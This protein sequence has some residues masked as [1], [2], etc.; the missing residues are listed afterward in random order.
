MRKIWRHSFGIQNIV[1]GWPESGGFFKECRKFEL[2]EPAQFLGPFLPCGLWPNQTE[3]QDC[4]VS[5]R[6]AQHV[7]VHCRRHACSFLAFQ[8]R[9]KVAFPRQVLSHAFSHSTCQ[10]H[11]RRRSK[12]FP[13]QAE[14]MTLPC[15]VSA[16]RA[17][18]STML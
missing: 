17:R 9:C 8:T 16:G 14:A 7:E 10:P 11:P 13:R 4:C 18:G 12:A 6:C 15:H 1:E 3:P 5:A 2:I